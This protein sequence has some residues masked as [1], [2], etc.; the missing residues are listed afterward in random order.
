MQNASPLSG[1][2]AR[3]HRSYASPK[4]LS[5]QARRSG[6]A[7]VD[8]GAHVLGDLDQPAATC[9]DGHRTVRHRAGVRAL[10]VEVLAMLTACGINP[11]Y[12]EAASSQASTLSTSAADA[13]TGVP[14]P[15]TTGP[16]STSG[17]TT[18]GLDATAEAES[19]STSTS[20]TPTTIT[21][22]SDTSTTSGAST[23]GSP[24]GD[25]PADDPSLIACYAFEEDPETGMMVDG[26]M[27]GF[28]G[29]RAGTG[30][31]PSVAGFGSAVDLDP[32]SDVHVIYHEEFV[33]AKLTLAAFIYIDQAQVNRGL[34]D[35]AGSYGL[36]LTEGRV[37]CRVTTEFATVQV[38]L[39]VAFD[40]WYH[41][42]CT[43][44][45]ERIKLHGHGPGFEPM[46]LE[47]LITG[48]IKDNPGEFI[49]GRVAGD[50]STKLHGAL[51]QVMVFDRALEPWQICDLAGPLCD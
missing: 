31:V 5:E 29:S 24:A 30:A 37:M 26:S 9:I 17:T 43:Y 46:P 14:P 3:G 22:T 18:G 32:G 12:D 19:T 27:S 20:S 34:I 36:Y 11:A 44:D 33:P 7:G 15:T 2:N 25:C 6:S 23:T 41:F 1:S 47:I 13:T 48:E 16:A 51:D 49:L 40:R 35:R 45:G 21:T 50:D 28:H 38:E 42:A 10:D 8:D 39:A 4:P